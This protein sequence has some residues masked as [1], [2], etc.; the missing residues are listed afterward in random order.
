L[1]T[2]D[3]KTITIDLKQTTMIPL[4][5][6]IQYDTNILEFVIMENGVDADLTNIGR[7]VVKYKRPDGEV[8]PR[9]LVAQGNII[10]YPIGQ[11]EM[12]KSGYGNIEIHFYSL[13]NIYR[14]STKKFK[15]YMSESLGV[16]FIESENLTLL[17]EL[18][19]EVYNVNS[20]IEAT[21]VVR[22]QNEITRQSQ[23]TLR[24]TNTSNK[25]NEIETR[26]TAAIGRIDTV[27]NENKTIWLSPVANFAAIATTYPNALDGSQVLVTDDAAGVQNQYRKINGS[28]VWTG[29][30]RDNALVDLQNRLND[31]N[32]QSQTLV[33]GTQIINAPLNSPVDIE[34]QG[35]TLTSLGN[36]N[37]E[38]GKNYVLSGKNFKIRAD[39]REGTQYTGVAKFTK[40][41]SLTTKA[42]F[43]GKVY[44]S[45]VENSHI[46]KANS[47][48]TSLQ[49]PTGSWSEF[50]QN[51]NSLNGVLKNDTTATGVGTEGRYSQQLFSFNIIEQIERKLGRI[52]S[53]TVAGKVQWIKDN[54]NALTFN[55]HGWGS[56]VGGSK[57]SIAHWVGSWV[58][59]T[60]HTNGFVTKSFLKLMTVNLTPTVQSDGFAH[61][62]AYAEPSDGTTP[63]T[64]NTDFVELEIELKSTAVLDTRPIITRV[65]TFEGKVGGSVVENPH[66]VNWT[67]DSSLLPPTN[68]Q[69][70]YGGQPSTPNIDRLKTLDGVTM[71]APYKNS[72]NMAQMVFSFN[73]IEEVERNIGRIPKATVAEKVQWLKDN[74]QSLTCDWSGFGSSVGGNKASLAVWSKGTNS[75]TS[76][77]T[78]SS[79]AVSKISYLT[80]VSGVSTLFDTDGICHYLAYAEPSDGTTPSTI[81]TDYVELQILLKQGA[82]LHDP[83]L[84]L[85]EVDAS[86]YANILVAW[87]ENAVMT[88]FPKVQGVQHLNNL[89]VI[90]EG[91]NLLP[92]FSEWMLHSNAKVVGAYELTH[93]ASAAL[94]SNNVSI[95]A[96]PSMQYSFK[97]PSVIRAKATAYDVNGVIISNLFDSL[98]TTGGTY[99]TPAN[100]ARIFVQLLSSG[101]G[102][103]AF[104]EPTLTLGLTPK[105][106][107]PRNPSYLFAPVK[108]GQ[109][110]TV[111]DSLFK[112]DGQWQLVERVKKDVVLDGSL[113][114]G[115]VDDYI[116]FKR[117]Q[118][119]NSTFTHPLTNAFVIKFDG[120]I[121][122]IG[123]TSV[124]ADKIGSRTPGGITNFT[125]SISDF[126][127]GLG[128]TYSPTQAECQAIMYGWQAKTVDGN[129]KPTAW[130]S[131]GD[132]TDAPTQT[133]AYVST[134]K[135]P[136]FT[137]DKLSYVLATPQTINVSH[138]VEGD[139]AVSVPTQV[140]V[141][142]GVVVREKVNP[143]LSVGF[144]GFAD[145]TRVGSNTK[146]RTHKILSVYKNGQKDVWTIADS[147]LAYG[148]QRSYISQSLFDPT[149]VYEVTYLVL[150]RHL[151]TLNAL[152]VKGSYSGSLK[153]TVDMQVEK[154]SDL[155]TQTSINTNLIYRLLVQAKANNW[156]V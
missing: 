55:W 83:M 31:A 153:D 26:T 48:S 147:D 38:G 43:V 7:I 13:D 97:F 40:G 110:G 90:A 12:A 96:L 85:Y 104:K 19:V 108:L 120:K 111:K 126:D 46:A 17:Q 64:L 113:A 21:E 61:F 116:G 53:D 142:S 29:R 56:S 18:F 34:V 151:Q 6:F 35:R 82:T 135:A 25:I 14:I 87:D 146:H 70:A 72:G 92:P 154:V 133:L 99:T 149:A 15:V 123:D 80:I 20:Q 117:F 76:P 112:T 8:I 103:N 106:F 68:G 122:P 74:V 49:T 47:I 109:I 42:D 119:V 130:R 39:G 54:V 60:P 52:P 65:A 100:T 67:G 62:L 3:K 134:T 132:G 89:A 144:Y 11:S 84:P 16:S 143:V 136:N 86:D 139:I 155:A 140:E 69:S 128:E 156:S 145:T 50:T 131:L 141:T 59:N 41:T 114:W 9:L 107:V 150:D 95:P 36:S 138:L 127:S 79:G 101:A 115:F 45:T 98:S 23:E 93:T 73:L 57:A 24:Q 44:Q 2:S 77:I 30:Y 121:I 28:W 33:H 27:V 125:I 4:P 22:K 118:Y 75:W 32:R 105:P 102:V 124:S 63:S 66:L 78:H 37:L 51:I 91:E 94:E 88:R 137:P 81:N 1:Q 71:S 58:N 129:G 152:E 5:Q 10:T 148:K